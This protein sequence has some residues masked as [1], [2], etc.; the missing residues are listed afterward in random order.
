M[1]LRMAAHGA[2]V[3]GPRVRIQDAGAGSGGGGRGWQVV[4]SQW[5]DFLVK[6]DEIPSRVYSDLASKPSPQRPT[7]FNLSKDDVD[8]MAETIMSHY[9]T[10]SPRGAARINTWQKASQANSDLRALLRERT[11]ADR[12]DEDEETPSAAPAVRDP[13]L[14]FF[15]P[16]WSSCLSEETL[17]DLIVDAYSSA[18]V[19]AFIDA[20]VSLIEVSNKWDL[21]RSTSFSGLQQSMSEPTL[22]QPKTMR[23]LRGTIGT[24]KSLLRMGSSEE[25]ASSTGFPMSGLSSDPW[26]AWNARTYHKCKPLDPFMTRI[27]NATQSQRPH[28]RIVKRVESVADQRKYNWPMAATNFPE[29]WNKAPQKQRPPIHDAREEE[30]DA[31]PP[32]GWLLRITKGG[33][34]TFPYSLVSHRAF[35]D[36]QPDPV[37]KEKARK[38]APLKL[39][40]AW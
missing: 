31:E 17:A 8:R 25:A 5:R 9:S 6:R 40:N 10:E 22:Q 29:S 34:T 35:L 24:D 32:P 20:G 27:N 39:T 28:R 11:P 4:R 19:D 2:T 36:S 1:T 23:K 12:R 7:K 13:S 30:Y 38:L 16:E 26:E 33:K 37:L 21:A 18:F 14:D 3:G 15:P